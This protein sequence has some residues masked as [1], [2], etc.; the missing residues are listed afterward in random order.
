M[1]TIPNTSLKQAAATKQP[2]E[3]SLRRNQRIFIYSVIVPMLAFFFLFYIYP[4]VV[5][6]IGSLTNW[7]AFQD[8]A[9]RVFTGLENYTKLF[10]DPVFVA[11]LINTFKYAL[12]YMPISIIIALTLALAINASGA[13]AGFFRTVYFL[14]VVTS[15]IATALI[16]SVG[17]YQP[18]YG[19]FNQVFALVGLPQQ[20]FLR[21]PD[22]ALF[23][24]VIYSIWKNVGYDIVIFM[25]GLTAIP[26]T[27][28]EAA[29]VDGAS[30]W[31][32]FRHITLPLL[33]PTIVFVIIT[34]I[35]SSLQV[36]GPIY[37]MTVA[38]GAD[39]PGG[40]L[41]STIVVGV[42]QWQVAFNE[43]RLGYGS[44][45]GMVLFFIILVITL[46]QS[47]FLR[48]RWEY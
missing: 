16:W 8:P 40:P 20:A 15:V 6:F 3:G 11:S 47:R 34:G 39:K 17:F 4:I 22:S 29:K 25:A 30:R 36:F 1:T 31:R 21:S 33:Q 42:Y 2:S 18:R 9:E 41:N 38:S 27:F 37:I 24:V 44:A 43:L 35:I 46:L 13:L 48:R 12:M 10:A 5:G 14:P 7:R 23:S 45:M 28:Y 19:L 32:V 26:P